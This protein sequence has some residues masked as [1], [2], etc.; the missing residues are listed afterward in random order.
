MTFD[1]IKRGLTM[2]KRFRRKI[3]NYLCADNGE[4]ASNGFDDGHAKGFRQAGV[5]E[6]VAADQETIANVAVTD[7]AQHLEK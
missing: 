6:D 5:E 3:I 7:F 2:S 1:G 4:S